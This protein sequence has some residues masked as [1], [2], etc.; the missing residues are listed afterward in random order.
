MRQRLIET[1]LPIAALGDQLYT[2]VFKRK[3]VTR[4]K[5]GK[6]KVTW[7]RGYRAPRSEDDNSEFIR[8]QLEEKRPAWEAKAGRERPR[9]RPATVAP[10]LP[11][12]VV[13]APRVP[14]RGGASVALDCPENLQ[15]RAG[16]SDA[17]ST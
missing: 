16:R 3:I 9:Y 13:H 15:D 2:V 5:R 17:D 7:Q 10:P 14:V 8:Q 12:G 4:T 1:W 6:K 11:C